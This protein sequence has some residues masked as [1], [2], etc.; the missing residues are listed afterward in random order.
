MGKPERVPH[1]SA[2]WKDYT[3]VYAF[4]VSIDVFL[5]GFVNF[6]SHM[7]DR[8][9]QAGEEC[10]SVNEKLIELVIDRWQRDVQF[11]RQ[12]VI[13]AVETAEQREEILQDFWEV[14]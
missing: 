14:F 4:V 8:A 12:R 13:K 9:K 10:D 2:K 3:Y 6:E 7:R 5:Y 11:E 1:L